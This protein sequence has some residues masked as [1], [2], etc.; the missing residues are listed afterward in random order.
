MKAKKRKGKSQH[1]GRRAE[2]P[3]GRKA[4][5]DKK[6]AAGPAK[7]AVGVKIRD[8]MRKDFFYLDG[9]EKLDVVIEKFAKYGIHEA[10]V[11]SKGELKGLLSDKEIANAMLE[12]SMVPWKE[13]RLV[14]MEKLRQLKASQ[15]M[16]KSVLTLETDM[17]LADAV[18]D[19]GSRETNVIPV[20]DA[21]K[22]VGIV[23]GKDVVSYVA[24]NI[25]CHD[26]G[27][28]C[29]V[30]GMQSTVDAVLG[31]VNRGKPVSSMEVAKELGM[32][33]EKVEEMARS[34]ARHG[35]IEVRYT[36]AGKM[37]LKVLE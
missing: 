27:E 6:A 1:R 4:E 19:M 11:L 34:L 14:P 23:T 2:T 13:S 15:I 3:K 5:R 35:L 17:G 22:V 7:M 26:L 24:K 37:E 33:T 31:I 25:I 12:K 30:G 18:R 20:V 10:P 9:E 32:T 29:W 21:G 28:A 16:K 8:I 36:I